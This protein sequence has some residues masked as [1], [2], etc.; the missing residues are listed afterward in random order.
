MQLVLGN[1]KIDETLEEKAVHFFQ[2]GFNYLATENV[3]SS[4]LNKLF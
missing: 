2:I 4:L 1:E 3:Q